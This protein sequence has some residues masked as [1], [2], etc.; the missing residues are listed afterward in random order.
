MLARLARLTSAKLG[1]PLND[2]QRNDGGGYAINFVLYTHDTRPIAEF[3][4]QGDTMGASILGRRT[5][6]C[7]AE[8]ILKCFV[9]II[10]AAP[11]ELTPCKLSVIDPE[12]KED[13]EWYTPRPVR[14]STNW[15]GWDGTRFLGEKNI[16][17]TWDQETPE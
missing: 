15:Y 4:F 6:D 7:S 13:P 12:W 17:D 9:S 14:G 16:R 1:F 5:D 11:E 8:D 3:Q 10:L 2:K